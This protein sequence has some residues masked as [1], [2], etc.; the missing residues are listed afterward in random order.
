M[1]DGS[2]TPKK[3]ASISA[4]PKTKSA[5]RKRYE[6]HT[7]LGFHLAL[8]MTIVLFT[9][10]VAVISNEID[11][12]LQHDMR[13]SPDG[14]RV[15]WSAMENAAREAAPDDM[16]TGI[17]AG[18]GDHFAY[19]AT[20]MRADGKRYFIHVNQ[21]TGEVT[22]TTNALTV[23]RF[24]RDLHRY[25][26]MP[27]ILG[28]P[29]VCSM[30]FVLAL[31]LYT[32]LRTA[33]RLKTVATRLRTDKGVRIMTGDLHKAAGVWSVWF[34]LVII[35]TGVWYLAEFGA[36]IA[37]ERFEPSRP[38]MTDERV[39]ELGDAMTLLSADILAEKATAA[40]PN[41]T[42]TSILF[43]I[44]PNQAVTVL[45][46]N[47]NFLIRDRANRVFL[48]PVDGSVIKAQKSSEIGAVAYLNE[49]A[50]PLHF[51]FFGGLPTKLI[52]FVFGVAMT[53]LS[54]TGVWLT[55][56]RLKKTLISR[57]QIAT[58][59]VLIA[60]MFFGS[61]YLDRYVGRDEPSKLLTAQADVIGPVTLNTVWR[62][63]EKSGD[64]IIMLD[65]QH[66][67]GRPLVKS[68]D[69]GSGDGARHALRFRTFDATTSLKGAIPQSVFSDTSALTL[70]IELMGGA[71]ITQ[72]VTAPSDISVP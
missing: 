21:W 1:A 34:F 5:K 52:W 16:L 63:G 48:D 36:G 56:R 67:A 20:M 32:G 43:P 28:L 49:M 65:I 58:M 60:A 15:S 31:S 70:D 3:A 13:V 62:K 7:W 64:H 47:G 69:V 4:R 27:S 8:I 19:R 59:P 37:G 68:V 53:G 38:G 2:V 22:G 61:V 11:W 71:K 66:Q 72:T 40:M 14:E 18:E 9:G 44:R 39:A 46:D 25:L 35:V 50:D 6:L 45:G 29:I 55:Y 24:F 42:A 10:T 23:Q 17:S 26:F 12:L 54:F 30:G 41:W 57:A 33:G 51:G